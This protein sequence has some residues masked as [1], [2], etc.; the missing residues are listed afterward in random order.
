MKEEKKPEQ[1]KTAE[2]LFAR[3]V[4]IAGGIGLLLLL[5]AGLVFYAIE[6]ILLLFGAILLAIFLHGLANISRRYLRIGEG[7]SVLLV[8]VILLGVLVTSGWMLAPSIA[9]QVTNLRYQLPQAAADVSRYLSNYSWGN[10]ILE[11]MP[12]SAEVVEK[13]NNSNMLSRVG[14]F[15]SSTAA[16][17]TNI[18]LMIL[19]AIYLAS[20]P[21]T[22]IKGFAKLFPQQNRKRVREILYEIGETLSWWLIGKGASM[23]FIGLLT[24]VGL[25]FIGVPLALS[26]GLIAGLLSFI[27]NFGPIL[28]AV[29]A[30]LLA[31]IDS[32]I[33][34]L[35]VLGLYV[36]VQLIESNLVTPMIERETVELPPVLTIVSQLAL[37]ILFGAPGLI[38]ATPILAVVM[39]LVQTLYIQ[40]VLGDKTEN[41]PEDNE[42]NADN[43]QSGPITTVF[44]K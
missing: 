3:R 28:S 39:V 26:L 33:S 32:P 24:W 11:Q 9:D 23:I 38:L 10:L 21:K 27:P 31:F 8:S 34:A 7:Y 1:E 25:S 35:Y 43:Q 17:L 12:S 44:D 37:A 6:V 19:L 36:G 18:A 30:I 42:S 15:F 5:I 2:N 4:L 16:I 14:G 41:L 13:V 20:E 22:Y 29:P 40:D